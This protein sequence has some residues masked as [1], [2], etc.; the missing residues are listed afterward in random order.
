MDTN[1]I[2]PFKDDAVYAVMGID[3]YGHDQL[4][5]IFYRFEDAKRYCNNVYK[6]QFP[7]YDLWIDTHNIKESYP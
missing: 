2:V 5:Q 7:Y 3:E 4:L 1:K 6:E